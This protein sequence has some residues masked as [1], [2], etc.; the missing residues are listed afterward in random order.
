LRCSSLGHDIAVRIY[1]RGL[2]AE[3]SFTFG[4]NTVAHRD[5]DAILKRSRSKLAFKDITRLG[6]GVRG[7][8]KYQGRATQ[9]AGS[10]ALGEMP[11]EAY[12]NTDTAQRGVIDPK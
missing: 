9:R 7:W 3:D 5:V 1:D 11:V 4:T 8:D 2:A 6:H 12:D 10:D